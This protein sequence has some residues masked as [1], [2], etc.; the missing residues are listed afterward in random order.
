ME[1]RECREC[2]KE[3]TLDQFKIRLGVPTNICKECANAEGRR[4]YQERKE[5]RA[6]G[7]RGDLFDRHTLELVERLLASGELWDLVV[8]QGKT[9]KSIAE[10]HG[11]NADYVG[12]LLSQIVS[13]INFVLY[14]QIHLFAKAYLK[15]RA[16]PTI[17]KPEAVRE[18]MH[19]VAFGHMLST[20]FG[21]SYY[22]M[23]KRAAAG[24]QRDVLPLLVAALDLLHEGYEPQEV[25]ETLGVS[26]GDIIMS[27]IDYR[28]LFAVVPEVVVEGGDGDEVEIG[29]ENS[30]DQGE[31]G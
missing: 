11:V 1:L 14:R 28:I 2:G 5:K 16:D 22:E 4:L 20:V 21:T 29:E 8:F 15:L 31:D 12:S 23:R 17:R 18:F 13:D 6:Q 26:L 19:P 3:K 9:I 7:D 27:L 25:A 24:P 10:E 30:E